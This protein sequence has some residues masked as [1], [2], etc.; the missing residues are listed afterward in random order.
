MGRMFKFTGIAEEITWAPTDIAGCKLWLRSDLAWQDAAKTVP[1]VADGNL[2][3]VGEDKSLDNDVIQ[4]TDTNRPQ[5]YTNQINGHPIWRFDGSNDAL[6]TAAFTWNDPEIIYIVFKP[7]TWTSSDRI[8]DGNTG[9]IGSIFQYPTAGKYVAYPTDNLGAK[10]IDIPDTTTAIV[11]ARFAS[12]VVGIRKN[13][14]SELT[15]TKGPHNMGGFTLGAWGDG[16]SY[17]GN[18]DVAEIIG[19]SAT[20]S[21]SDDALIMDYLNRRYQIY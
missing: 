4:A 6:R 16:T 2:I 13:N 15:D 20:V 11:R 5:Y 21:S 10:L 19:Y 9:N 8:F 1:C 14:E 7:I 12:T 17:C 3:Y 18:I